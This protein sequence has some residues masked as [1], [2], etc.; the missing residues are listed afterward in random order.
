[1]TNTIIEALNVGLEAAGA[2]PWQVQLGMAAG[3]A[4]IGIIGGVIGWFGHKRQAHNVSLD[5]SISDP[6]K[7]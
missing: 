6:R 2:L 5:H 4:L 7:V 3:G 1:M